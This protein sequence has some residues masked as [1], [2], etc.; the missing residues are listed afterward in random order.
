MGKGIQ[1]FPKGNSPKVNVKERL[2]FEH[3][4]CDVPVKNVSQ[5][6][7]ATISLSLSLSLY[8]YIYIYI[9]INHFGAFNAEL[10]F[11]QNSSV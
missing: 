4:Y 7:T 5:Y 9:R 11:K 3:A 1:S 10:G 2:E 6:A 8:I